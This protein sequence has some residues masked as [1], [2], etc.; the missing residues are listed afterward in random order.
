MDPESKK[1]LRIFLTTW[2]QRM[3][4][5]ELSIEQCQFL[6]ADVSS[7]KVLMYAVEHAA[8]ADIKRLYLTDEQKQQ[9]QNEVGKSCDYLEL[10]VG[11]PIVMYAA[12]FE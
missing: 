8:G 5:N 6:E 3:I 4:Q 11:G 2:Q 1:A 7:E 10:A 12:R 9:I